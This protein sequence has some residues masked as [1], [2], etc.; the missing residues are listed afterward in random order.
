[1]EP[2]VAE[3]SADDRAERSQHGAKEI[4]GA[5]P[6]LR[7][8]GANVVEE[9]AELPHGSAGRFGATLEFRPRG[10]RAPEGAKASDPTGD[11]VQGIASAQLK[12]AFE[13]GPVHAPEG[14]RIRPERPGGIARQGSPAVEIE[15]RNREA[16]AASDL[17]PGALVAVSPGA[18]RACVEEHADDG[19]LE[20]AS[21][22]FRLRQARVLGNGV[23][24]AASVRAFEM[25][26][27][28]VQGDPEIRKAL[29]RDFRN[30]VCRVIE[31][32]FVDCKMFERP[33]QAELEQL[34]RPFPDRLDG[35]EVAQGRVFDDVHSPVASDLGN[36]LG[37]APARGCPPANR[38]RRA[39][40]R[41]ARVAMPRAVVRFAVQWRSARS[42]RRVR[43]CSANP[44]PSRSALD[45]SLDGPARIRSGFAARDSAG[46]CDTPGPAARAG[47]RS[48]R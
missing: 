35:P 32:G 11:A 28:A 29:A 17:R 44:D 22:A 3:G 48:A 7:R 9:V 31:P 30:E 20:G 15:G 5:H 38:R 1:M 10:D 33:S 18:P 37:C 42:L 34:V 4:A 40:A 16:L 2:D 12:R 14:A 27:A 39:G 43:A 46:P 19:E 26:P 25:A 21:G 24:A 6:S 45:L 36:R 23:P 13:G 8:V 41:Q 47:R